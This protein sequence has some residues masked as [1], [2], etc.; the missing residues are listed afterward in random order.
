M[1]AR[2]SLP[3]SLPPSVP[4]R[5]WTAPLV[6]VHRITL[7]AVWF[8]RGCTNRFD[9][10][11]RVFGVLYAGEQLKV[12]YLETLRLR[13]APG[14]AA[15]P[16][17]T[18]SWLLERAWSTLEPMRPLHLVDLVLQQAALK[19]PGEVMSCAE[20]GYRHS[21]A[22]SRCFFEHPDAV[23]GILYR[24][25]H[26]LSLASAVLFEREDVVLTCT[27][28]VRFA[29]DPDAAV[30]LLESCGHSIVPDGR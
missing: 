14:R 11:Q 13:A 12:A 26:D 18:E 8:G 2:R 20:E 22:W 27:G 19:I 17:P 29:D 24:A 30:D 15:P 16:G 23:D 10:P 4:T 25:R 9:D 21:Q 7:D 3:P 5:E 28:T 1:A 6:R